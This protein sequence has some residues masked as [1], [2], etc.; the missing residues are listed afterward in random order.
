[1][2]G[3]CRR[4]IGCNVDGWIVTGPHLQSR[5]TPDRDPWGLVH[6]KQNGALLTACRELAVSWYAFWDRPFGVGV[7]G[8]CPDCLRAMRDHA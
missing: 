1:M 7:A 5:R 4:G 2:G 6:V 8:S 3:H